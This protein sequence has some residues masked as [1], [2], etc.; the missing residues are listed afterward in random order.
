MSRAKIVKRKKLQKVRM[1]AAAKA[2]IRTK[3]RSWQVPRYHQAEI[4]AREYRYTYRREDTEFVKLVAPENFSFLENTNEVLAYFNEAK[5]LSS[6]NISAFFDISDIQNLSPDA[7][8][9]LMAYIGEKKK[10]N[11]RY[12][13]N[14]PNDPA[15]KKMFM[16]SGLYDYVLSQVNKEVSPYNRLWKASS[17]NEVQGFI[18]GQALELCKKIL[19]KDSYDDVLDPLYNLLVEAM[20]NTINHADPLEVRRE[21]WW[22]Y[23]YIDE[24][25]STI[26]FCF[27]DLGVG[28]FRS[29][30]FTQLIQALSGIYLGTQVLVQAL[31]EG[32]IGSSRKIDQSISGKGVKQILTCGQI[33]H[34]KKF[35]IIT[36]D[37]IIDVKSQSSI[38]LNQHFSGTCLYW[39]ISNA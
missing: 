30:K 28:I 36:N 25:S 21:N 31:F 14:A 38:L 17:N 15:Y 9:L 35:N 7:I 4:T 37:V 13:G 11:V 3:E 10:R 19:H 20:S 8:T 29:A 12:G 22:L 26:K 32:R 39:E 27:V 18:A 33:K 23:S 1:L 5:A 34:F 6:R 16:E 2:T 24:S